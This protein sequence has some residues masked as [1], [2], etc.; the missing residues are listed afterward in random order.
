MHVL[1]SW[2]LQEGNTIE[3]EEAHVFLDRLYKLNVQ[4]PTFYDLH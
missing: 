4:I 3:S 2:P 1:M